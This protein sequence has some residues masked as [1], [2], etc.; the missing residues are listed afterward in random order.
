MLRKNTALR[1]ES[2]E[3]VLGEEQ[4]LRWKGFVSDL[5]HTNLV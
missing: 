5:W 2:V 4:S 3:L 1:D